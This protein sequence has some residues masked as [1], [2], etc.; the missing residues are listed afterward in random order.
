MK[1][2]RVDTVEE[3]ETLAI[4]EG[5]FSGVGSPRKLDPETLEDM[6]D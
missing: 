1:P 4:P 3:G 5:T 2:L 6:P